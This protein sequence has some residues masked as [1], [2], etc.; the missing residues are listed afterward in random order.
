MP[1]LPRPRRRRALQDRVANHRGQIQ[2][3]EFLRQRP[4]IADVI[5]VISLQ[6]GDKVM[7]SVQARMREE[8]DAAVLLRQITTVERAVKVEFPEVRWSFFEPEAPREG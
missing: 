2:G 5:S 1:Y 6:L 3:G 7:L 4:E 8:R